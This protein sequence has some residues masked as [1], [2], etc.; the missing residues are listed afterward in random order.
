MRPNTILSIA[1]YLAA[2]TAAV[3]T[4]AGTYE[5]HAPLLTSTLPEPLALLLYACWHLVTVALCLSAWALLRPPTPRTLQSQALLSGA[6]GILWASFGIVFVAVAL[7]LGESLSTLLVLPQWVLL[8]PV[9][10]LAWFGSRK[11]LVAAA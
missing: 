7:L 2:F 10:A 9:G 8:L 1:G 3:H 11:L 6:I 5:V 4:F